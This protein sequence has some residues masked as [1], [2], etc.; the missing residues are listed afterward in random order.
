MMVMVGAL[1]R[2][3]EKRAPG[4]HRDRWNMTVCMFLCRETVRLRYNVGGNCRM[5]MG[6]YREVQIPFCV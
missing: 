3:L 5:I 1:G 4:I 2:E 6:I